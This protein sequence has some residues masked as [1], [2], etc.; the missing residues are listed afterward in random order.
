MKLYIVKGYRIKNKGSDLLK[1]VDS[2]VGYFS[3]LKEIYS[4]F[5]SQTIS[6]YSTVAKAM[7]NKGYFQTFDPKFHLEDKAKRYSEIS[8]IQIETNRLYPKS[9]FINFKKQI[10]EEVSEFQL[11]RLISQKNGA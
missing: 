1:R 4:R 9:E 10:R 5:D 7:T 11:Q 6:S 3:N 2:F 8:I